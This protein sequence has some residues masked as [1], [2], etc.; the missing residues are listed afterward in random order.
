MFRPT[1]E[2]KDKSILRCLPEDVLVEVVKHLDAESGMN[3]RSVDRFFSQSK[4]I[5]DTIWL[6]LM[7]D[8]FGFPEK[9][10]SISEDKRLLYARLKY[11]FWRK[12]CAF[13]ACAY[14]QLA[15][16]LMTSIRDGIARPHDLGWLLYTNPDLSASYIEYLTN[17]SPEEKFIMLRKAILARND[18]VATQLMSFSDLKL[19]DVN[20]QQLGKDAA[21]SGDV[22]LVK[23]IITLSKQ[24]QHELNPA[25]A[26]DHI[27]NMHDAAVL[28]GSLE[29]VKF[30]HENFPGRPSFNWGVGSLAVLEYCHEQY[31]WSPSAGRVSCC[32]M[33]GSVEL[34]KKSLEL[35]RGHDSDSQRPYFICLS[36]NI[37]LLDYYADDL[38]G[39]VHEYA[40]V[41]RSGN[42]QTCL[43]LL[44]RAGADVH[45][46]ANIFF[47]MYSSAVEHAQYHVFDVLDDYY[48]KVLYP[49]ILVETKKSDDQEMLVEVESLKN[50][51][52]IV[53]GKD[54]RSINAFLEKYSVLN[55]DYFSEQLL[56]RIL[57]AVPEQY[58]CNNWL[59]QRIAIRFGSEKVL[60]YCMKRWPQAF[61]GNIFEAAYTKEH[62]RFAFVKH[63]IDVKGCKPDE[64]TIEQLK[65]TYKDEAEKYFSAKQEPKP[66]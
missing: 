21:E 23:K 43:E 35:C 44:K 31:G 1:T 52:L 46:R 24:Y 48:T 27:C 4:K 64:E 40:A 29:L 63:L 2:E 54:N 13:T 20:L 8:Q 12:N 59:M 25:T 36:G 57:K 53:L 19:T 42:T 26:L 9:F 56:L 5:N 22:G 18:A 34:F 39:S 32:A 55:R 66:N 51:L 50:P 49:A 58:E 11:I 16:E 15:V 3:L 14:T 38:K 45:E 41:A 28:S 37:K 17:L 47:E 30:L 62:P 65:E 60:D 33:T 10:A 6:A 61:A 7:Q